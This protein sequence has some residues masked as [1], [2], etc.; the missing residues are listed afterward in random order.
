MEIM[1]IER[2]TIN[3]QESVLIANPIQQVQDLY[4]IIIKS[5]RRINKYKKIL[6]DVGKNSE[7]YAKKQ[8]KLDAFTA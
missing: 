4:K 8:R 6:N 5:I 7:T 2:L 1:F 3:L